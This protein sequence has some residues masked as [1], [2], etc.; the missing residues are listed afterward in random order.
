[1]TNL[2]RTLNMIQNYSVSFSEKVEKQYLFKIKVIWL[3]IVT[4]VSVLLTFVFCVLWTIL[5][6]L[7]DAT[8]T[9]CG[10]RVCTYLY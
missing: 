2:R 7:D 8:S 9:H 5:F 4:L 1:M 6:K 3:A 10:Y